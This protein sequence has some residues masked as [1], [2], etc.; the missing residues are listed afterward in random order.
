MDV[1]WD[2]KVL[3]RGELEIWRAGSGRRMAAGERVQGEAAVLDTHHRRTGGL[4]WVPVHRES[5][6]AVLWWGSPDTSGIIITLFRKCNLVM[7]AM[8]PFNY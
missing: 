4:I 8:L 6:L 7:K 1:S 5:K 3:R 2:I